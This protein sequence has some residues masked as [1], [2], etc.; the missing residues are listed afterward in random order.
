[1]ESLK[2]DSIIVRKCCASCAHKTVATG[3][4]KRC[5]LTED[6]RRSESGI[7]ERWQLSTVYGGMTDGGGSVKKK[8][9]LEALTEAITKYQQDAI[10]K[11]EQISQEEAEKYVNDFRSEYIRRNGSIY[12]DI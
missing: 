8:Q 7:C 12:L 1:M 3:G 6:K 5:G 9:Y 11:G 4:V 2:I 10:E